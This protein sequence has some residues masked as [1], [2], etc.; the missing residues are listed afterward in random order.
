MLT[1]DQSV[2]A[3]GCF[4]GRGRP[5]HT[6]LGTRNSVPGGAFPRVR[7]SP[8]RFLVRATILRHQVLRVQ[9]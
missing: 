8:R 4:R 9:V 2:K 5:R 1:T 3:V 7:I 6:R